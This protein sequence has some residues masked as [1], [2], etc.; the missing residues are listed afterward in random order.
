[1]RDL[2]DHGRSVAEAAE[3]LGESTPELHRRMLP[4]LGYGPQHLARVPRLLR[5]G[6]G[7]GHLGQPGLVRRLGPRRGHCQEVARRRPEAV[8]RVVTDGTP[9]VGG[10]RSTAVARAY[11]PRASTAAGGVAGRLDAESPIRVPLTVVFS[12][13]DGIVSWEACLDPDV[14]RI[15]ADRLALTDV[16]QR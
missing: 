13:R 3:A 12:R 10:P 6:G 14:W 16:P 5:G 1:M 15:V 11:G 9:V 4:V 2:L 8:R 7:G